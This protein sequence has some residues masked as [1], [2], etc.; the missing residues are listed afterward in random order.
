MRSRASSRHMKWPE[1]ECEAG[2]PTVFPGKVWF[3]EESGK[4][5]RGRERDGDGQE[6]WAGHL[7]LDG[8]E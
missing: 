5:S 6:R 2:K 4:F 1:Q 8:S 7:G 3:Q